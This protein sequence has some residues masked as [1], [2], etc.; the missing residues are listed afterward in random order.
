[1]TKFASGIYTPKNPQKYL[2]K[3]SI[4]YR[5][6]WELVFM[7]FLDNNP[8][9][10]QWASESVKIPYRNPLTGK[11]SIYVPDFII[12]YQDANGANHA[13]CIEIKPSSQATMEAAKSRHDKL[14]VVKNMAK[15][16]A[17]QQFC[18]MNNLTFRIISE[19]DLF[20]YSS[21]K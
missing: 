1:M 4:K 21:R 17:C 9:V 14:H 3:A 18:K 10:L 16:Q 6:S 11:Q 7:R 2:G 19:K 20:H 15:W 13:E 8:N 12:V 5:S